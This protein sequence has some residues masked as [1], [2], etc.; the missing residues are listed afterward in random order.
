MTSDVFRA[1][2]QRLGITCPAFIQ[3]SMFDV[4]CSMFVLCTHFR[5]SSAGGAAADGLY[6]SSSLASI[7]S[8]PAPTHHLFHACLSVLKSSPAIRAS[9]ARA[10][11]RLFWFPWSTR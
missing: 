4:E 1:F 10:H 6:G 3:H 2:T 8:C 11:K 7:A 5:F 9:A